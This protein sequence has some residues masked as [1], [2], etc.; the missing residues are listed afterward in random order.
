[1]SKEKNTVPYGC[2]SPGSTRL[3]FGHPVLRH[4]HTV[5]VDRLLRMKSSGFRTIYWCYPWGRLPHLS[6]FISVKRCFPLLI[7]GHHSSLMARNGFF[8]VE[9]LHSLAMP[10][11]SEFFNKLLICCFGYFCR[12]AAVK[13]FIMVLE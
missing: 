6:W 11:D 2:H 1:M 8:I 4:D 13:L 7:R 5:L 3:E 10:L 12:L 9:W